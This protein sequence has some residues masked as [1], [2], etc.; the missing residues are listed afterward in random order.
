MSNDWFSCAVE[1]V[2]PQDVGTIEVVGVIIILVYAYYFVY[3]NIGIG[4]RW[5]NIV[6]DH[7]T[8]V[9]F[10]IAK[11]IQNATLKTIL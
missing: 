2:G 3:T 6:M 1:F 7:N 9:T 5:G 8:D 10:Y 11:Q 4:H